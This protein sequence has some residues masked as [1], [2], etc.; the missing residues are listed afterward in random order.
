VTISKRQLLSLLA[1]APAALALP[2][3]AQAQA[4]ARPAARRAATSAA[5]L[6]TPWPTQPLKIL[7]GFPAGSTPDLAARAISEALA[8]N[9]G[10]PVVVEN[11]PGASGNI[12]ADLVARSTDN[13]TIGVLINGNLTVAKMLNDKLPFDPAK[14]FAPLS[15]IGTAPLLLTVSGQATGRTPVEW[16]HWARALEGKGNYGT[17]GVGTVGHLGMELI[18]SKT[19]IQAV[20][21]PFNGNPQVINAMLGGQ[22][23][24]ALLPPGLALPHVKSGKLKAV[25]LTSP[26]RSALVTDQPTLREAEVTGA[27]L[28]IWTAA[29]GPASMPAPVVAKLSAAIVEAVRAP[30]SR[31]R[32]LNAGW[33]AVGTAPEG[34]ANRMKADTAQLGGI[35]LMRGIKAE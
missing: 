23:H 35:I 31:Q 33:Q 8:R 20:H 13:H 12:V 2:A 6:A 5:P 29:A 17:P 27:D 32:L 14:D 11:R 30:E 9:L 3:W 7:V 34:L 21:V 4:P 1:S 22:V 28:E 24:M 15:L 25:G 16:L 26:G 10:Q 19:G 18:K